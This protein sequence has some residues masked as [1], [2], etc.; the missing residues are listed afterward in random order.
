LKEKKGGQ[1]LTVTYSLKGD[2]CGLWVRAGGSDWS[3]VTVPAGAKNLYIKGYCKQPLELSI[4]LSDK[5]GGQYTTMGT[6]PTFK[7]GK[8]ETVV[9]PLADFSLDPYY[10]PPEAVKGAPMDFTQIKQFNIQPKTKG[11]NVTF[12]IDQVSV[13]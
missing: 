4:S 7:G 2:Y 9:I 3:R 11:D 1:Y 13:K 12:A 5:N 8:W 6:L 10:Q